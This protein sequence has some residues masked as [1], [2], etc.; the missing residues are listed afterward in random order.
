M[1]IPSNAT[2]VPGKLGV[3]TSAHPVVKLFEDYGWTWGGHFNEIKDYHHFEKFHPDLE[4]WENR[5]KESHG[6]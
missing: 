3:L 1:I 5:L 4:Y 6:S 2:Y